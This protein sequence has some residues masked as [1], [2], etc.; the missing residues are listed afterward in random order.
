MGG[1]FPLDN[2]LDKNIWT[3]ATMLCIVILAL[4]MAS[5]KG[6]NYAIL[7]LL[8]DGY[9]VNSIYNSG[10]SMIHYF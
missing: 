4:Y 3:K 9:S 5:A 7:E 2:R 10:K 8:K 6:D 1:R